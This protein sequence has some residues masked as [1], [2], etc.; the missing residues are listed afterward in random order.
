MTYKSILSLAI[1]AAFLGTVG[2]S[3]PASAGAVKG[4][5]YGYNRGGHYI[6]DKEADE[7]GYLAVDNVLY[8]HG[9]GN[10]G[11]DLDGY[12][13]PDEVADYDPEEADTDPVDGPD[14]D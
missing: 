7:D 3:S 2:L 4:E 13:V 10:G 9:D 6:G 1:A 5:G 14:I 11:E 8:D 12:E